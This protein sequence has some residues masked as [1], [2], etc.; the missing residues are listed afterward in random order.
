M[1]IVGLLGSLAIMAAWS[2]PLAAQTPPAA[3]PAADDARA[4]AIARYIAATK[5]PLKHPLREATNVERRSIEVGKRGDGTSIEID[6]T[7]PKPAGGKPVPVVVLLHGGLP[8][9]A[10]IRPKGSTPSR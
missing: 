10:T 6:L 2:T 9:E 3:S 5:A 1:K 7:F 4:Q 8:D